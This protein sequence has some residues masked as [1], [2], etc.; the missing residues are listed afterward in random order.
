MYNS[1][2]GKDLVPVSNKMRKKWGIAVTALP[3]FNGCC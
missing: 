2:F 3:H 1:G